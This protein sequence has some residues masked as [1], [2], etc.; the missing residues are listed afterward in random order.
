M[1]GIRVGVLC[2]EDELLISIGPVFTEVE[3]SDGNEEESNDFESV[4]CFEKIDID[5]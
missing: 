1:I 4:G 2:E 3:E 5:W